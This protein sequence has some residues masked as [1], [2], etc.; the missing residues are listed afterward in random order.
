MITPST[1]YGSSPTSH[2]IPRRKWFGCLEPRFG[3]DYINFDC[4]LLCSVGFFILNIATNTVQ[5]VQSQMFQDNG[6]DLLGF[7]E[8][9]L[10]YASLAFGCVLAEPVIRRSSLKMCLYAGCLGDGI[11]VAAQIVPTYK[12]MYNKTS[13]DSI[14]YSDGF[15]YFSNTFGA[16]ASGLGSALLWIA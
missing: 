15:V 5:F 1:D 7:L 10:S 9:G 14:I 6:Y 8:L 13:E 3:P 11:W 2:R 12:A 4:A 16:L